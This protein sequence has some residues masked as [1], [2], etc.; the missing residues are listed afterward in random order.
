M[1]I[2]ETKFT[3][4]Q[5]KLDADKNPRTID[6]I[7]AAGPLKGM[8]QPGIYQIEGNEMRMVFST[9]GADRHTWR[10]GEEEEGQEN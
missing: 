5:I 7:A 6:A 10:N 4:G 9:P 3:E 1:F 2:D 8:V